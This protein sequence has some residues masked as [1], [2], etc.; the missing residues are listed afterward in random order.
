MGILSLLAAEQMGI[1]PYGCLVDFDSAL[2]V[3]LVQKDFALGRAPLAF[4]R[5]N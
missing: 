5:Q 4:T 2:V 1:A 3:V